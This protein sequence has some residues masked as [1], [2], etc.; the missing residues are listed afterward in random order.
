MDIILNVYI[1]D[2]NKKT[3]I[4]DMDE[5]LIHKL[6]SSDKCTDPDMWIEVPIE[7]NQI[8]TSSVSATI[9]IGVNIRP[10]AIECLKEANKYFEVIVFTAGTKNY[11]NAILDKLDPT[12]ELIQHRLYRDSCVQ[13]DADGTPLYIK[14]LRIFE[15]RELSDIVIVDNAVISFAY[16]ID[17]GIPILPFRE[18]KGDVEFLHLMNIMKDISLELDCRDFVKKAFKLNEI[19]KTDMDSYIHY[20][21]MSESDSDLD[22]DMYLD[23]LAQAQR[24][25]ST[26]MQKKKS[27]PKKKVEKRK[28]RISYRKCKKI[29]SECFKH[30]SKI[31]REISSP[32][33]LEKNTTNA[34]SE[35]QV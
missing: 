14:D 2:M 20:Y 3:M 8:S 1:I 34:E 35:K 17:N 6:D 26:H 9:K 16:Q 13:V 18:D 10:Y 25:L 24:S 19:M 30:S 12:G 11:A 28:K 21:D 27:Q 31:I 22:D 4:F 29:K 33:S 5:T 23:M 32:L 7:D 15:N